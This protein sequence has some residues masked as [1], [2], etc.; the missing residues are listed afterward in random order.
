MALFKTIVAIVLIVTAFSVTSF[1]THFKNIVSQI[2][3][4]FRTWMPSFVNILEDTVATIYK[5]CAERFLEDIN[6]AIAGLVTLHNNGMGYTDE[7]L[8]QVLGIDGAT[9]PDQVG[10]AR[11]KLLS[12]ILFLFWVIMGLIC[13]SRMSYNKFFFLMSGTFLVHAFF[14]P[15]WC[16]RWMAFCIGICLWMGSLV[17]SKPIPAAITVLIAFTLTGLRR[18]TKKVDMSTNTSYLVKFNESIEQRLDGIE[19]KLDLLMTRL[20]DMN[21]NVHYN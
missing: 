7:F 9:L 21:H 16:I 14:G 2:L 12:L 15:V 10:T 5:Y 13:I 3:E 18:W 4:I 8:Q 1:S 20:N 11:N 19:R 6:R 17:S